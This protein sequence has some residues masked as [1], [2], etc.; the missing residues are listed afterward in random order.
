MA[1]GAQANRQGVPLVL[2][3]DK[4]GTDP[5]QED[6]EHCREQFPPM[7]GHEVSKKIRRKS[8]KWSHDMRLRVTSPV[9]RV[10][11]QAAS[12]HCVVNS[13][14]T[15]R[16]ASGTVNSPH[17]LDRPLA[18]PTSHNVR[19][20]ASPTAM[21]A[22]GAHGRGWSFTPIT[23][24][25][26]LGPKAAIRKA[27]AP[28]NKG[29]MK[30]DVKACL[31]GQPAFFS[32]YSINIH[33]SSSGGARSHAKRMSNSTFVTGILI[34]V[35]APRPLRHHAALRAADVEARVDDRFGDVAVTSGCQVVLLMVDL[36]EARMATAGA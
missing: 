3:A 17:E 31:A 12:G 11:S 15:E 25:H 33:P 8:P 6:S 34:I 28:E 7:R 10:R 29:R 18:S 27:S 22:K 1:R 24:P 36:K 14:T 5:K 35:C 9:P 2:H 16:H 20:S 32:T 23:A 30:Q 4:R 19:G 26:P 13:S 21:N